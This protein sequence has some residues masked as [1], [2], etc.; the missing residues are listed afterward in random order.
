ML[1]YLIIC[2]FCIFAD[3]NSNVVMKFIFNSYLAPLLS[4]VLLS[5][6]QGQVLSLIDPDSEKLT[7]F[8]KVSIDDYA[9]NDPYFVSREDIDAYIEMLVMSGIRQKEE[10]KDITPYG[11]DGE[12]CFYVVSYEDGW[13]MISSDKRGPIFL[14]SGTKGSFEDVLQADFIKI[15]IGSLMQDI[16]VRRSLEKNYGRTISDETKLHEEESLRFWQIVSPSTINDSF[17]PQTKTDP[18]WPIITIP[19]GHWELFSTSYTP[20]GV[21]TIGHLCKTTWHQHSPYNMYCPPAV[22]QSGN[23]PAGCVAI[24]GSQV[25]KYLHDKIGTPQTAPLNIASNGSGYN[26]SAD[27]WSLM[28]SGDTTCI[29]ALIRD[30]GH[31]VGMFYWYD[32]S[33]ASTED[34]VEDV[35]LPYGIDATYEDYNLADLFHSLESGMPVIVKADGTR[36]EILGIPIYQHGHSFIIDKILEEHNIV[37][38]T[39]HWIWD[40]HTTPL[41]EV[42]DSIAISQAIVIT[43]VGMR[44]GWK[45]EEYFDEL[46]FSP[47]GSWEINGL[48]N[49]TPVQYMFDYNR[50]MIHSF[51]IH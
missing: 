50:A 21:D 12:T 1:N 19:D 38:S 32:G 36:D 24:S 49:G 10:I 30:V 22:F 34:L 25:L 8:T 45:D 14:S 17:E 27:A 43:K 23:C 33:S 40:P 28:D 37:T 7:P 47:S 2:F 48:Q 35:F 15:W 31:K 44:W 29:A 13:E 18:G 16:S 26:F 46:L 39:Y 3:K 5:C 4:I 9:G 42:Q 20:I 51:N 41:P 11:E 6:S